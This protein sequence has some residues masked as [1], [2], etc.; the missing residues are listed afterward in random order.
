MHDAIIATRGLTRFFDSRAAVDS[1]DVVVPAGSVYGFLGPNGA[2]KTTTIR[3]LL[4]LL[5]PSAG[6]L[7][8]F[9]KEGSTLESRRRIGALVEAPSLYPHLTAEENLRHTCLLKDLPEREIGRVLGIADLRGDATRLVKGFSL[10]MK[11]RLG[12]ANSLL[13]NPELV[14]LDEPTNG[15]DPAGIQEVRHLLRDMPAQHGVTVFLSSHLLAE[16]E[17]IAGRIGIIAEGR[18]QFEGTPAELRARRGGVLR[19]GV[20]RPSVAAHMLRQQGFEA[21]TVEPEAINLP[22]C[23]TQQ[24]AAINR[25]LVE[26]GFSVYAIERLEPTLEE[27]FLDMTRNA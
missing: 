18:L 27:L 5:R 21:E 23:D 12:L 13:G 4:G 1:L 15:L 22:A 6:S 2:G 14:I 8:L 26:R 20:E 17:Q 25:L 24:S 10:G 16:V 11:Q 7:S 3:M 19:I 9:G